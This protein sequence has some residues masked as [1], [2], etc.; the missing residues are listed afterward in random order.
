[1]LVEVSN[2]WYRCVNQ[3]AT[4]ENAEPESDFK[5]NRKGKKLRVQVDE[6][7]YANQVRLSVS[8]CLCLSAWPH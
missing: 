5:K 2:R 8:L 6:T 7:I 3:C 4:R 1:M